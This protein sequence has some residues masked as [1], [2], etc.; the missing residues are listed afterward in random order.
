[1]QTTSN[2]LTPKQRQF[3]Q[4]LENYLDTTVYYFGSVQRFDY[5]PGY[6]DVDTLI[7]VDNQT[8]AIYKLSSFLKKSKNEM[9]RIVKHLG[10]YVFYGHKILYKSP[11]EDVVAE[12]NIFSEKDKANYLRMQHIHKDVVPFA[13]CFIMYIVKLFYYRFN[14]LSLDQY[15]SIKNF[16]LNSDCSNE[17]VSID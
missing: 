8:E 2:H 16:F 11:N 13:I 9:K 5:V 15:R 3:F 17:F 10:D 14:I 1:M 6:S 7:F 4:Q 12:I